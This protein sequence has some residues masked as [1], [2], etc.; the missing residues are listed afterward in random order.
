MDHD[1]EQERLGRTWDAAYRIYVK[2]PSKSHYE[3]MCQA[4]DDLV[5]HAK[6]PYM[7]IPIPD[8]FTV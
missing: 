4:Y 2:H 7:N 6:R 8:N 3:V 1:K 5:T